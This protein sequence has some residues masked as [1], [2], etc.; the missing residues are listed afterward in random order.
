[1]V[2]ARR[3]VMTLQGGFN[4]FRKTQTPLTGS[5]ALISI[6]LNKFWEGLT[7]NIFK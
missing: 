5:T 3:E 6:L 2:L 7:E 1:M 4:S